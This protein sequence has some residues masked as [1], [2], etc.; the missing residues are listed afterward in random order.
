MSHTGISYRNPSGCADPTAHNALSAIQGSQ[1]QTDER[2]NR[3]IK[4]LK[5][6][7]D[8]SGYDLLARIELR[9]RE[10]GRIYR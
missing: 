7:I 4:A 9:D 3:M 5:I 1:D 10:T 8:Q 6:L 2:V